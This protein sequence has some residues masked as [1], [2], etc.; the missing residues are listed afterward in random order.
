MNNNISRRGYFAGLALQGAALEYHD[1]PILPIEAKRLAMDCYTIADAMIEASGEKEEKVCEWSYDKD[2]GYY[3]TQCDN[4]Q[5][6]ETPR[7]LICP[8]CGGRI[9]VKGE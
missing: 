7:S 8:S 6:E 5:Y 9:V 3:S 4:G 1:G 2:W